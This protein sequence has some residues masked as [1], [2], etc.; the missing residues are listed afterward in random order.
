MEL[1]KGGKDKLKDKVRLL[2]QGY[3]QLCATR[4]LP[5]IISSVI[6]VVLCRSVPNEVLCYDGKLGS[7]RN[8]VIKMFV[9]DWTKDLGST[10]EELL[11]VQECIISYFCAHKREIANR[12]HL[13][14]MLQWKLVS[15]ADKFF[16]RMYDTCNMQ[17]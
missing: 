13:S 16:L 15:C 2:Y 5:M 11:G 9:F 8:L 6:L 14:K 4:P 12:K 17:I 7:Q 10:K 3:G 1:L